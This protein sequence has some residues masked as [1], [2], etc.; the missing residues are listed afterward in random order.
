MRGPELQRVVSQAAG[1]VTVVAVAAAWAW[2]GGSA[3]A[4]AIRRSFAALDPVVVL[5]VTATLV[6]VGVAGALARTRLRSPR[7]LLRVR[8]AVPPLPTAVALAAVVSLA[9]LF[10]GVLA[11]ATHLP[12]V[13]GDELV[14]SGLAKGWAL[15]GRPVLRG[16]GEIGYSILYP[17]FLAP[18]FELAADG[19]GALAATRWMNATAMAATAVPAY[20]LARRVV[21]HGWALC[22]AG[23]SAA[24]PWTAYS[25]LT[26]TESLFYPLF[27]AYAAVLAWTL[28]RPTTS[29]QLVTLALLA[30]LIGVRTQGLAIAAGTLA[31]IAAYGFRDGG[32]A[33]ARRF[34]PTL[35]VLATALVGGL[36]AKAAGIALPTATYYALFDS[37]PSIWR[38]LEWAVWNVAAFELALGVVV[39]AAF[40]VAL[41]EMLGARS[42]P[43]A[44]AAGTVALTLGLAVLASVVLLSASPYGLGRLHER[45]LFFLTP[46]LL[47]CLAYWLDR[48]LERP[49]LLAPACALAAIATAVTLPG[50]AVLGTPVVD[51]PS[52]AF[53]RALEE[54][55]PAVPFRFWPAA[56]AAVGAATF[57]FARRPLFPIVSVVLAFVAVTAQVDYA[58]NLAGGEARALSWVDQALPQD[59]DATLVH[60]GLAYSLEPCASAAAAEQGGLVI[61]TEYLNTRIGA[62]RYLYEPNPDGLGARALTPAPGGLIL[63][64]GRPFRPAYVVIDSR[65]Q[66][67]GSPIVRLDLWTVAARFRD[68]AS[69][70]LWR[71]DPP[72]RIYDR[73]VPL[74]PR[75]DGRDC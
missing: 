41:K 12:N 19:A 66:I 4:A 52:S 61:W 59:A 34:R 48:G 10:R 74:P 37:L 45:S 49:R 9:A 63:D 69:L 20:L 18:A 17:L 1:V 30:A 68:G 72:L 53:F 8:T 36:A 38:T 51:L 50:D 2:W 57:L 25:A 13:L 31:A 21:P 71:V 29:R 54:Q 35:A 64:E 39:I 7:R 3:T 65:Q 28:E 16:S 6:V 75:A 43:A 22:V 60:L 67:V 73:P 26:M 23:L 5:T 46:L 42:P 40:P 47:T 56:I 70:T 15:H 58:D 14:Y 55:L 32:A 11:T 44:C 33:T 62:V 27:V 24:A